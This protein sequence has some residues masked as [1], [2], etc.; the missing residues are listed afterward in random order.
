MKFLYFA[1]FLF[2]YT[3]TQCM[4]QTPPAPISAPKQ[5][6]R[7]HSGEKKPSISFGSKNSAFKYT[8]IQTSST[9]LIIG[10]KRERTDSM[11]VQFP[12]SD[13]DTEDRN[14]ISAQPKNFKVTQSR[15]NSPDEQS[16]EI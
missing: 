11:I 12:D 7:K 5:F 6:E 13:S 14:R 3:L 9:S 8:G 1:S 15:S 10:A 16:E 2:S 4:D